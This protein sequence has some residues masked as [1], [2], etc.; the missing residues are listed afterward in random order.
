MS[1]STLRQQLAGV[2]SPMRISSLPRKDRHAVRNVL[3]TLGGADNISATIDVLKSLN[4][5]GL[6]KIP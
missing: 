2:V 4:Y 3:V 6:E 1:S 5:F